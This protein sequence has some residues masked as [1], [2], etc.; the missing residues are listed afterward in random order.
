MLKQPKPSVCRY[1]V[2]SCN[3]NAIS[4]FRNKLKNRTLGGL[5]TIGPSM[6][7]GTKHALG[8][9]F[10]NRWMAYLRM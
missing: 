4:S 5:I 1:E 3:R 2:H 10:A 7:D 6:T 9:Q 8:I